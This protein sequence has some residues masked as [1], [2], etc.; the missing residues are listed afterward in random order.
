M[1]RKNLLEGVIL[2]LIIILGVIGLCFIALANQ[3]L[4]SFIL[5]PLLLIVFLLI[6]PWLF[7]QTEK[8]Y[9]NF[10]KILETVFNATILENNR[11][12]RQAFFEYKNMHFSYD[13]YYLPG[14]GGHPGT[15]DVLIN[16]LMLPTKAPFAFVLK[17]KFGNT[18]I[19]NMLDR[20][21]IDSPLQE[22][23]NIPLPD[24]LKN[25]RIY[26][27]DGTKAR[28]FISDTELSDIMAEYHQSPSVKEPVLYIRNGAL[29]LRLDNLTK[30]GLHPNFGQI[31]TNPKLLE[32][33]LDNMCLIVA[34]LNQFN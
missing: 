17:P 26:G 31:A 23:K 2:F 5:I 24:S 28:N 15:N 12:R 32:K 27:N 7:K 21:Y 8:S 4:L 3:Q 9:S 10:M 30:Y 20:F 13:C 25:C 22:F 6:L 29:V 16:A 34:K 1:N 33:H 19:G 14:G 18:F 11:Y